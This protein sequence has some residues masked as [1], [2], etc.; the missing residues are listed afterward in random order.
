[1]D[2]R[3]GAADTES[4]QL[5]RLLRWG[6][7]VEVPIVV[8]MVASALLTGSAALIA[9]AAQSGVALVINAFAVYAM[10]QVLRHNVYSH[11][12]GAGKLENFSAF[13]CGV[14]YIPSGVFVLVDS[15]ERLLHPPEVGYLIG[16]VP[17]AITF[18]SGAVF[19]TLAA[20]L[21]RRTVA[22]S[23]LLIAYR[24]DYLIGMLTDGGVLIAF[25]AGTVLVSLGTPGLGDRIDPIVA[26]VMAGYMLWVGVDLVRHNFRALMDLPLPEEDQLTITRVLAAHY[27]DYDSVGTLYTRTSGNRRFVEVELGFDGERTVDH[28]RR[29]SRHME[30]DLAADVPGLRFRIVPRWGLGESHAE[31]AG[32]GAPEQARGR[33][34]EA[35]PGA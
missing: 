5:Y 2:Q 7:I 21:L 6:L 25:A 3:G 1:V 30:R 19:F 9:M 8:M 12:Y 27:A 22:P 17:V 11:P 20:R 31:P 26:L 32:S 33:A 15:V 18:A 13:L 29:L 35:A 34:A 24:A 4:V 10:R 16:L 14:L 28:V 23:P